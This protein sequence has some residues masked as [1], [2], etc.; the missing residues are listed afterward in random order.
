M[1]KRRRTTR[2]VSL[3]ENTENIFGDISE[4][5]ILKPIYNKD[6]PSKAELTDVIYVAD[7]K[8]IRYAA[9]TTG[10]TK[11]DYGDILLYKFPKCEQVCPLTSLTEK[12]MLPTHHIYD[13]DMYCQM[14]SEMPIYKDRYFDIGTATSLGL[15]YTEDTAAKTQSYELS[16]QSD[17]DENRWD[18]FVK[19]KRNYIFFVCSDAK[20][21][22]LGD[23]IEE[24]KNNQV[25]GEYY[26]GDKEIGATA[27]LFDRF[28][29]EMKPMYA[30]Y[31]H[32]H[33]DTVSYVGTA[34]FKHGAG[35]TK[36]VVLP[37]PEASS[38]QTTG[39]YEYRDFHRRMDES[40]LTPSDTYA[41]QLLIGSLCGSFTACQHLRIRI[42]YNQT[43]VSAS[44]LYFQQNREFQMPVWSGCRVEYGSADFFPGTDKRADAKTH[45]LEDAGMDGVLTCNIGN[46]EYFQ[47]GKKKL[48]TDETNILQD[49]SDG[50]WY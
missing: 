7:K 39:H 29:K 18:E 14:K 38:V 19:G 21:K 22:E 11:K 35:A 44:T 45:Q 5:A 25:A 6:I 40:N 10:P 41:N 32:W 47:N 48:I 26:L 23:W 3:K 15:K 4:N 37:V 50:K 9:S 2:R 34:G 42:Y 36:D 33:T 20:R 1:S 17:S 16:A 46:I 30:R 43:K 13:V 27:W 31:V 28:C 24:N 49:E 12:T 8:S